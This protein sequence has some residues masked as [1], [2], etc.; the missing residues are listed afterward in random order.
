MSRHLQGHPSPSDPLSPRRAFKGLEP[1]IR[2]LVDYDPRSLWEQDTRSLPWPLGRYRRQVRDFARRE[3]A[4]RALTGDLDPHGEEVDRVLRTAAREGLLTDFLP[5]PLGTGSAPLFAHPIQLIACLKMEELCAA[6][7]GLGLV[8]GAH[9]LGMMPLLLS[10]DLGVIRRFLLPAFRRSKAG[11][12]SI[13]AFAITEPAAG[14]DVEEST[15]AAAYTP[16][17]VAERAPGGWRLNGRKVFISGGDVADAVTL[18]AALKGEGMAS[19]TCFLVGRRMMGFSVV[20]T[21]HKMGQR[22]SRAAEL[23]LE[24]V[25]VPDDHVIGKLRTGWAINRATLNF[26][27]IPVGAIALGIARGAMEAA[28]QLACR[29]TLAGKPLIDYQEVQ[30]AVAQMLAETSAMRAL[31]WQ[32]AKSFV[33]TQ[34]KAAIAKLYCG[35]AAVRVCERAMDLLGNH[36]FMHDARVEKHW[37]DARLTQIYEG[38]NQ[39]NRLAVIE[40]LQEQLLA[41]VASGSSNVEL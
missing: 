35:D 19:W 10:G 3:L 24:D 30:L 26:S 13:F 40:D 22:A 7:A 18:F 2:L 11:D 16:R 32:S 5:R 9:G 15:G 25:F 37:R 38:T 31:I 4:P 6:C 17:T 28:V 23:E 41:Q 8:L 36:G 20:R 34:A 39:I 14:S 29:A 12:P 33:P 27:R 21:E 1:A